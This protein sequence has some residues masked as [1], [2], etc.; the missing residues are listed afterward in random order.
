MDT[1]ADN[2]STDAA[3][4]APAGA[5]A[6][7]DDP[8]PDAR[9]ARTR[10]GTEGPSAAEHTAAEE[11]AHDADAARPARKGAG[12]DKEGAETIPESKAEGHLSFDHRIVTE[13]AHYEAHNIPG[14]VELS[15][16]FMDGWMKGKSKG[17]KVEEHGEEAYTLRLNVIVEY[18]SNCEEL[19]K[20]AR[21]RISYAVKHMT[22]REVRRIDMHIAGIKDPAR[23][24]EHSEELEAIGEEHGIDF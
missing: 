7:G 2:A 3:P 14:I 4:L 24:E 16:S 5:S 18:G 13:I 9:L 23:K 6:T 11:T 21:D 19:F 8:S 1:Q 17:I 22:G 12:G 15:G 10:P 20:A